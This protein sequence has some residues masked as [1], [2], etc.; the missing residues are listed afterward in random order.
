MASFLG[1]LGG[2]RYGVPNIKTLAVQY[3]RDNPGM[4]QPEADKIAEKVWTDS[5]S[6]SNGLNEFIPTAYTLFT[7]NFL[8]NG[9]KDLWKQ[10][11]AR[12]LQAKML[13]EQKRLIQQAGR[14]TLLSMAAGGAIYATAQLMGA[15]LKAN[16][17]IK[18]EAAKIMELL[19]GAIERI[20]PENVQ[21]A[22]FSQIIGQEEAKR[23]F[24][25]I[26]RRLE[27]P[28]QYKSSPPQE[29]DLVGPNEE[30]FIPT[31]LAGPPG[32]GKTQMVRA[33]IGE[34]HNNNIPAELIQLHCDKLGF[35]D[36]GARTMTALKSM[37]ETSPNQNV[38]IFMDEIDSMGSRDN[39]KSNKADIVNSLLTLMDGVTNIP[40]KNIIW[41][42]AT[43][44]APKLDKAI[45]SRFK[46]YIGFTLPTPQDLGKL[47][48]LYA[49]QYQLKGQ[50]IHW[51]LIVGTSRGFSG[52]DVQ[53]VMAVIKEQKLN[54]LKPGD[55]GPLTF[56]QKDLEE[57]IR[58]MI[59]K[60]KKQGYIK[61]EEVDEPS[62]LAP[63]L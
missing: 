57:A 20:E 22:R 41:L 11:S 39:A 28:E 32:V 24:R 47:Y 42:G 13:Q 30:L 49:E 40:D 56:S 14:L 37:I 38:V 33:L 26:Q 27:H 10:S 1:W 51:P 31:L 36:T 8:A 18:A 12:K 61:P 46:S 50:N 63:V 44:Y 60:N 6:L 3:M 29:N 4:L 35:Q 19:K 53:S 59:N 54:K 23:K 25:G 55:K 17:E 2:A 16:V 15:R 9:L 21:K 45:L 48:Q 7:V 5:Y 34:L 62:A 58:M 43:N 52:R